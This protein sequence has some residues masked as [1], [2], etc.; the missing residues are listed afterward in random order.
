MLR[1]EEQWSK[2]QPLGSRR[3][4]VE[5]HRPR[6]PA[7]GTTGPYPS[8]WHGSAARGPAAPGERRE[9]VASYGAQASWRRV[10][11]H[12]VLSRGRGHRAPL[13]HHW[14]RTCT[15]SAPSPASEAP[16]RAPAS[17]SSHLQHPAVDPCGARQ[18]THRISSSTS[19]PSTL[20]LSR[21][22]THRPPTPTQKPPRP[23]DGPQR[24]HPTSLCAQL[25]LR[26]YPVTHAHCPGRPARSPVTH[27]LTTSG[28]STR[29]SGSPL[30]W[31]A[32]NR[33]DRSC[34]QCADELLYL[35][36]LCV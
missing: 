18:H 22:S 23:G 28:L 14:C 9:T 2:E 25:R 36:L 1:N 8:Q 26:V 34:A 24:P 11:E 13:S 16:R 35:E 6:Q 20:E 27:T 17:S 12:F 7:G 29:H 31:K 10:S 19:P 5:T 21:A 32:W 3:V 4:V 30:L 33:A 15:S